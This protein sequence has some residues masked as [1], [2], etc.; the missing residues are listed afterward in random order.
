MT[1]NAVNVVFRD[2]IELIF[3]GDWNTALMLRISNNPSLNQLAITYLEVNL[4]H[5]VEQIKIGS[6]SHANG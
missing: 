3:L 6:E 5:L 2:D 4:L 1:N